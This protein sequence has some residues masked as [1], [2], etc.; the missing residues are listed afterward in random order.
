MIEVLKT[1]LLVLVRHWESS[2]LN[3]AELTTS[4]V[5]I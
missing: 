3:T 5:Y 1:F 4:H 2:P